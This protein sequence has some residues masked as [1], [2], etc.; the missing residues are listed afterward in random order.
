MLDHPLKSDVTTRR[1]DAITETGRRRWFSNGD[2]ALIV[3]E[4]LGCVDSYLS[5]SK[6]AAIATTAK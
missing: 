6:V 2:K 3:Q 4:T 5:Q 1:L